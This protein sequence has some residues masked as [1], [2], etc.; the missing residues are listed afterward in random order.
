MWYASAKTV[1]DSTSTRRTKPFGSDDERRFLA[2]VRDGKPT[3]R[4]F[5]VQIGS[6][7]SIHFRF[8]T[9]P[10]PWPPFDCFSRAVKAWAVALKLSYKRSTP[11]LALWYVPS[12]SQRKRKPGLTARDSNP[13][14][15]HEA[16]VA[17]EVVGFG[18]TIRDTLVVMVEHACCIVE[19]ITIYLTNGHQC[20]ERMSKRVLECDHQC[21]TKR[22]WTPAKLQSH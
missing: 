7:I 15:V 19:D 1:S 4:C 21:G 20:L 18:P 12:K 13:D 11:T 10:L 8:L 6:M 5:D 3:T 22:K 16:I 17:P 2:S 9:Y 14:K